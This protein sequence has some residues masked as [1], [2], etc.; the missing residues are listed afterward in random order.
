M[1]NINTRQLLFCI[2]VLLAAFGS[3]TLAASVTLAWN[4]SPDP[5]V[6]GYDIY[7]WD[8][9]NALFSANMVVVSNATSVT[10]SNLMAGTNYFFAATTYNSYGVQSQLSTPVAYKIPLGVVV[11]HPANQAPTLAPL[12][13]IGLVKG[14]GPQTVNL[15]GISTGLTN[16]SGTLVITATSSNTSLIPAPVVTYTSPNTNGTLTFTPSTVAGVVGTSLITV[17]ANNQQPSNNI[18]TRSFMVTIMP[19]GSKPPSITKPPTNQVA[20][21]GQNVSFNVTATG[22]GTLLYQWQCNATNVPGATNATLNL[23]SV[24]TSQAGQYAV[25]VSNPLGATNAAAMLTVNATAASLTATNLHKAGQ[26]G[27]SIAGVPGSNY[28]VQASTNLVI[29]IALQTNA[30]PFAFMDTNAG[31]FNRRFYRAV[32]LP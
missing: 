21:A 6:T 18:T 15:T 3:S 30:A 20:V 27:L 5:T 23:A 24:A 31:K 17:T 11:V 1:I 2:G 7:Y 16:K 29:W 28:A 32:Y 12:D 10:I 4:P 8:P 22:S 19:A 13:N 25:T 14:S 26:F 9:S